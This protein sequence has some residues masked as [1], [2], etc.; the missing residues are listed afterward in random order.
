MDAR[1]AELKAK[2]RREPSRDAPERMQKRMSMSTEALRTRL[3]TM[4]TD[5][6]APS[7]TM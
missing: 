2:F 6:A 4:R 3:A 7:S 1:L 5:D